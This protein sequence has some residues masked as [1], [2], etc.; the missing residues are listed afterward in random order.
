[1]YTI[2]LDIHNMS[3]DQMIGTQTVVLLIQKTLVLYTVHVLD[4]FES[5]S[6]WNGR[7]GLAAAWVMYL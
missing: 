7:M 3:H 4:R 6:I 1:M 5:Y 2:L